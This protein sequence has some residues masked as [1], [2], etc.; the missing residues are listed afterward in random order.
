VPATRIGF[1]GA[2]LIAR[3]H[4]GMLQSGDADFTVTAVYDPDRARADVLADRAGAEPASSEEEVLDGCDAVYVCTWTSEHE[5]LVRAAAARN[6]PVFCEKPLSTDFAGARRMAD[7]AAE[8][9][10]TNQ[11]GLVLR[12]SPAFCWI[13]HLVH[14]VDGGPV[15]SVFLRDD[16][17]IPIQGLYD[18]TWRG[19]RTRA[20]A[21]TLLEHSI[22]DVDLLEWI[23]GRMTTVTARS[24]N[25]H[26][27]DGIEDSVAATVTL[28]SGGVGTMTSVWHDVLERPSQRRLEVFTERMWCALEGTDWLGPVRWIRTGEPEQGLGGDE[29]AERV[30]RE[31]LAPRNPDAEFVRAVQ[32]GA[33][34]FPDFGVALR[35]HELVDAMYRSAASGGAPTAV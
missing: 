1:L 15:M 24:A 23:V 14:D 22:H 25:F 12:S 26:R 30:Y 2:G 34:A 29:L 4:L 21:G 32:S 13:R 6:L 11:V 17:Y 3:Y 18:S 20:G 7:A 28:E 5:H 16:Q 33:P 31:G 27:I 9:G 19:D 10:I 8:A 35:A